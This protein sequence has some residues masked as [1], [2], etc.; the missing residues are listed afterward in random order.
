M[1]ECFPIANTWLS[2]FHVFSYF[3]LL[4]WFSHSYSWIPVLQRVIKLQQ[5]LKVYNSLEFICALASFP[6]FYKQGLWWKAWQPL[7]RP[8]ARV[9]ACVSRL[10]LD[11]LALK[12]LLPLTWLSVCSLGLWFHFSLLET[13][14]YRF[15]WLFSPLPLSIN[16]ASESKAC[17][18]TSDG[19]LSGW[20]CLFPMQGISLCLTCP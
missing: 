16:L 6:S 19:S 11:C 10:H 17:P 8:W 12:C 3:S 9:C 4:Y 2:A 18:L 14:S 13:H 20:A 15:G 7:H 5:E 1:T